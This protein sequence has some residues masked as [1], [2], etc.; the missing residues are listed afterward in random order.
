MVIIYLYRQ[1]LAG[2]NLPTHQRYPLQDIG[3]A[4]LN[5]DLCGISAC[6]VYPRMMLPAPAVSSYLTFSSF[7]PVKTRVVI[8][9][10]TFCYPRQAGSTRLLTGALLCAVRTFLPIGDGSITR[11]A[12]IIFKDAF[13]KIK[14]PLRFHDLKTKV[15]GKPRVQK[16]MPGCHH[17]V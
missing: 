12:A 10:G 9:C 16:M 7:P 11:F 6:K 17:R 1:L 4:A 3:R 13:T 5:A 15:A 14:L 2:I 8:F